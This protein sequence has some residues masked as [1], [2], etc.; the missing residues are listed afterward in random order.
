MMTISRQ[1]DS[2]YLGSRQKGRP[3]NNFEGRLIDARP[4]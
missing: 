1:S 4:H 2:S 3:E